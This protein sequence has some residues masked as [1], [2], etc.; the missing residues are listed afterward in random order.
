MAY[1][2]KPDINALP[3]GNDITHKNNFREF[4]SRF[5]VKNTSKTSKVRKIDLS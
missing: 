3:R 1:E 4:L 5:L 2:Q